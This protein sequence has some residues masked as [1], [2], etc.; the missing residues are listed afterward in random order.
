MCHA[1]G[2]AGAIDA[3]DYGSKGVPHDH[4]LRVGASNPRPLLGLSALTRPFQGDERLSDGE[5][6]IR[7]ALSLWSLP[8]I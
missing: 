7:K 3:K 8:T 5:N 4:E 2:A 1:G 6:A